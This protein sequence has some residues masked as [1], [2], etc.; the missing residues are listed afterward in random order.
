MTSVAMVLYAVLSLVSM[1][2]MNIGAAILI[3]ALLFAP[4]GP[5]AFAQELRVAMK[6]RAVRLYAWA[7]V[8]VIMAMKLSLIVAKFF[9]L[10]YGG[11]F[12]T[13]HLPGDA[14]KA[15]YFTL[16]LFL[17]VGW[18]RLKE[19]QRARVLQ[20]WVL[21]FGVLSVVG[22][23]Q[24]FTGWPRQQPNPQFADHFHTSL[25]FGHHLST[26]NILIFPFFASLDFFAA[27]LSSRRKKGEGLGVHPLIL[28]VVL[29]VGVATL[30]F[31]YSRTLWIALPLGMLLWLGIQLPWKKFILVVSLLAALGWGVTRTETVQRRID[32]VMGIRQRKELWDANW[33]FFRQRPLTGVGYGKNQELSG[34]YLLSIHPEKQSVFSGHAHNLYLEILAGM[35]IL[36]VLAFLF[37]F[38]VLGRVLAQG[39]RGVAPLSFPVGMLCAWVVFLINGLTQ[40]NFFEGK[41][42]HQVMW[43]TALI[44]FWAPRHLKRSG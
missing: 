31:T 4:P 30:F 37:W 12:A 20:A 6:D 43:C 5:R 23:F 8:A 35:G 22:I 21:A 27:R 7:S 44:L 26:A 33:E 2:T 9:P 34:Y 25:F 14:M 3:G 16:P 19:S 18:R 17:L 38:G 11:K 32:T 40:V 41:V 29:L 42:T 28:G 36:G 24:V 1:A 39:L 15:W 10:S 13:V